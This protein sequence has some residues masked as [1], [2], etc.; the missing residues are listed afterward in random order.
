MLQR[1]SMQTMCRCMEYCEHLVHQQSFWQ[2]VADVC[3]SRSGKHNEELIMDVMPPVVCVQRIILHQDG[4]QTTNHV[5]F[6]YI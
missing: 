4:S 1:L 6:H 5:T 3:T 2:A